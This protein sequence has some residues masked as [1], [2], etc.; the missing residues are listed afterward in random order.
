MPLGEPP[1]PYFRYLG[2]PLVILL[3]SISFVFEPNWNLRGRW[4]ALL[5]LVQCVFIFQVLSSPPSHSTLLATAPSATGT[6]ALAMRAITRLAMGVLGRILG[7]PL[8]SPPCPPTARTPC[9]WLG[10]ACPACPA[11]PPSPV[12]IVLLSLMS[13]KHLHI[14]HSDE[15]WQVSIKK[16]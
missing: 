5:L 2:R 13:G 16:V 3:N 15:Y 9:P 12:R 8:P 1:P 6:P 7:Y 11:G 14:I 4:S 10:T